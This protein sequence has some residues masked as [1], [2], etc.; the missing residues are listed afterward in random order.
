MTMSAN[1]SYISLLD[2]SLSVQDSNGQKPSKNPLKRFVSALKRELHEVRSF[3]SL[4]LEEVQEINRQ[5]MIA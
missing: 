4:S 5:K 3:S 2:C 1:D